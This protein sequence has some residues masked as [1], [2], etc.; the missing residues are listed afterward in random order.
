M[1]LNPIWFAFL[2]VFFPIV[3]GSIVYWMTEQPADTIR[4]LLFLLVCIQTSLVGQSL[5]LLIGAATSLQ[6]AVF[7]GPVTASHITISRGIF[8][9]LDQFRKYCSGFPTYPS[10]VIPSLVH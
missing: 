7:L 5:G 10:L 8:L 2:Q 1:L 6:V 9:S 3:Y 4:F